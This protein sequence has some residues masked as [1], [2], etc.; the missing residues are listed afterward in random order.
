MVEHGVE[1]VVGSRADPVF[2]PVIMVGIG[3]VHVEI[4]R[5]V[6]FGIL[7]L[8]RRLAGRMLRRLKGYPL[9]TGARGSDPVDIEALETALLR[10]AAILERHPEILEIEMNPL[11]A[12]PDGVIAIDARSRVGTPFD[13]SNP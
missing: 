12:R 6:A 7:P 8:T 11:I 4:M 2:G 1:V 3:G 10:F 13:P 5:D 9:L